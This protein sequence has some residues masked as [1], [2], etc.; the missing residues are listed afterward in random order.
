MLLGHQG[1]LAWTSLALAPFGKSLGGDTLKSA[2]PFIPTHQKDKSHTLKVE[3]LKNQL[4]HFT[5]FDNGKQAGLVPFLW[6]KRSTP[7]VLYGR[8]LGNSLKSAPTEVCLK[9]SIT[10]TVVKLIS[11]VLSSPPTVTFWR[12]RGITI[13]LSEWEWR[14][15]SSRHP[16]PPRP[17]GRLA[18]AHSRVTCHVRAPA[19]PREPD[20]LH[21]RRVLGRKGVQ[22][23]SWGRGYREAAGRQTLPLACSPSTKVIALLSQGQ[24]GEQVGHPWEEVV[25]GRLTVNS[26]CG[27]G[28]CQGNS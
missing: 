28:H 18:S 25:G 23:K 15:L 2:W 7:E 16:L 13:V 11:S 3:E 24:D 12:P 4:L 14:E 10:S 19:Q 5:H 6:A 9:G 1:G 17:K 26:L 20:W 21:W 8:S 27:E 22:M